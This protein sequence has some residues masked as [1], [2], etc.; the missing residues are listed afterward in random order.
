MPCDDAPILHL[1]RSFQPA[2]DVQKPPQT[3]RMMTDR[4]EHQLPIDAV[5]IALDV[6][7]EHPVVSPATLTS[8]PDNVDR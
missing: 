5:K 2:L 6:K 1:D 4:L 3:V 8:R 7:I